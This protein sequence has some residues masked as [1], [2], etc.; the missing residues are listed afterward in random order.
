MTQFIEILE[1]F[2]RDSGEIPGELRKNPGT[3]VNVQDSQILLI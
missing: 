2:S 3:L 1:I